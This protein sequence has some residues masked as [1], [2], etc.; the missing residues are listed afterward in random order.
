MSE[1]LETSKDSVEQFLKE[2]NM[3]HLCEKLKKGGF[4]SLYEFTKRVSF[5][6]LK[7]M[8]GRDADKLYSALEKKFPIEI[9]LY[10]LTDS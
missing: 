1:S 7:M 6:D 9:S 4:S 2:I 10:K 3:N 5:E 8:V